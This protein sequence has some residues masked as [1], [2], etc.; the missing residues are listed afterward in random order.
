MK[1]NIMAANNIHVK[2]ESFL[3]RQNKIGIDLDKRHARENKTLK[4]LV[5]TSEPLSKDIV[6]VFFD[7]AH[8]ALLN[9]RAVDEINTVLHGILEKVNDFPLIKRFFI[10]NTMN[11]FSSKISIGK[12]VPALMVMSGNDQ[13]RI[14]WE[15][16]YPTFLTI[17]NNVETLVSTDDIFDKKDLHIER[18]SLYLFGADI[19]KVIV[20]LF[21]PEYLNKLGSVRSVIEQIMLVIKHDKKANPAFKNI[22]DD[23][24][25]ISKI[26]LKFIDTIQTH[27][28]LFD[29]SLK[30]HEF[31]KLFLLKLTTKDRFKKLNPFQISKILAGCIVTNNQLRPDTAL[32]QA[33][34]S[35]KEHGLKNTF[36]AKKT[37]FNQISPSNIYTLIG[38]VLVQIQLISKEN[39]SEEFIEVQK[40][41]VKTIL[42]KIWTNVTDV[43]ESGTASASDPVS[44][45]FSQIT[46]TFKTFQ[47]SEKKKSQKV[48]RREKS[49]KKS[50]Y[51]ADQPIEKDQNC[52]SQLQ[53]HYTL[54][55]PDILAF[56]GKHEGASQ[57]DYGYNIRLFKQDDIAIINFNKCFN[58]LFQ[59]QSQDELF[60]QISFKGQKRILEFA[61]AYIFDNYLFCFGTTH[62]KQ[63]GEQ[64]IQEKDIFPYALLFEKGAEK[65][66]G[67]ILSREVE[68][69][70]NKQIYNEKPMT[71]DN[72][73]MYYETLYYILH[74]MPEKHWLAEDS[75]RCLYF[76]VSEIQKQMKNNKSMMYSE[77]LLH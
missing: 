27:D 77:S 69:D 8:Q 63:P 4:D 73:I 67:R 30:R 2:I 40:M 61:S 44:N 5:Q 9:D 28:T 14:I 32:I 13:K 19:A 23:Q 1:K 17:N 39:L 43:L 62:T 52:L 29:Y 75:Q 12:L 74:L 45:L 35:E 24:Q 70:G 34:L 26:V 47:L 33:M 60:K 20:N 59:S 38:Q 54:V 6:E 16:V 65:Q 76:L 37:F 7:G 18:G 36:L 10:L 68:I 11:F 58:R 41:S 71:G 53:K 50:G 15:F 55:D 57:K 31:Y 72:M 66:F 56:R 49:Q 46:N 3:D 42:K 51:Q 48:A 64:L 21:K 22:V 25:C